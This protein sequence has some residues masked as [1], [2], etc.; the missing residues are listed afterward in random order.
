MPIIKRLLLFLVLVMATLSFGT[1]C[2]DDGG[3][4]SEDVG[5]ESAGE[6]DNGEEDSGEEDSGEE[7]NGEEDNGEEDNGEEDNAESYAGEIESLPVNIDVPGLDVDEAPLVSVLLKRWGVWT[8]INDWCNHEY[9]VQL[10]DDEITIADT[11]CTAGATAYRITVQEPEGRTSGE[12]DDVVEVWDD[13]FDPDNLPLLRVY[14]SSDDETWFSVDARCYNWNTF[15]LEDGQITLRSNSCARADMSYQIVWADPETRYTG[16]YGD[17]PLVTDSA[18][19][20]DAP[21]ILTLWL[22]YNGS[23]WFQNAQDTHRGVPFEMSE[24]E[25]ALTES[26]FTSSSTHYELLIGE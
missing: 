15:T 16:T 5:G 24:G 10:R 17:D 21:P 2:G 18:L 11:G 8:H 26:Y 20:I 23:T 13:A 7:D 12:M 1:A 6:E 14:F 25:V 19:A 22:S 3:G 4:A 9:T